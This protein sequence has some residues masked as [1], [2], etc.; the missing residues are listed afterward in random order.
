MT[1][2][3]G[4]ADETPADLAQR[5]DE[6]SASIEAVR[7]AVD[8]S[9]D[10]ADKVLVIDGEWD[11][12][13]V[14]GA[15]V[16]GSLAA[17]AVTLIIAIPAT[18]LPEITGAGPLADGTWVDGSFGQRAVLLGSLLALWLA[19]LLLIAAAVLA[20]VETR[21]AMKR[22]VVPRAMIPGEQ[23]PARRMAFQEI[24]KGAGELA[25]KVSRA[26]GTVVLGIAGMVV[27]GFALFNLGQVLDPDGGGTT[28]PADGANSTG[29]PTSTGDQSEE[30]G[31]STGDG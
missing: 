17:L 11:P 22:V 28:A 16:G 19:S 1:H 21:A 26:R 2:E 23:M 6:L 30:T 24:L 25:D 12:K 5:L 18:R 31:I 4:T 27:A 29:E 15:V 8:S 20:V 9:G 3:T 14:L 13:V 10:A 7:E